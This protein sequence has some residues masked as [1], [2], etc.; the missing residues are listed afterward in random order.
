MG[1]R[2][3]PRGK[4][5]VAT[6]DA[7]ERGNPLN[8]A[9]IEGLHAA[10]DQAE[11]DPALR[12]LAIAGDAQ[13]FCSGM[14]F[15]EA[16]QTEARDAAEIRAPMERLYALFDR[17]SASEVVVVALVEGPATAGGLGLVAAS[18]VAI[19]TPAASFQL[20]EILFG[21]L[22]AT[23]APFLV[24]RMGVQDPYRMALTAERMDA[25]TALARRL[26]DEVVD[27]PQDALRRL[28][29]RVNRAA[30]P[31]V[32]AT[33]AYFR[34]LWIIDDATRTRAVEAISARVADPAAMQGI[35]RFLDQGGMSWRTP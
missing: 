3:T 2:L 15:S 25:A 7:P 10:L 31:D 1:V 30:K 33:K 24:R 12:L 19:A 18:D 23:I 5:L 9:T 8:R 17:F 20:S 14:D 26:V 4:I 11:A 6:L 22:P 27:N 34:S 29:I 13:V 35:R 21:L 32:A 16:S 28:M